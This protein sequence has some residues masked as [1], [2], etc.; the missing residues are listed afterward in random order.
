MANSSS[1]VDIE[2]ALERLMPRGLGDET[3]ARLEVLIDELASE[4]EGKQS[5]S[6]FWDHP[7]LGLSA[8][9]AV[10]LAGAVYAMWERPREVLMAKQTAAALGQDYGQ[11]E[12]LTHRVWIEGGENLGILSVGDAGDARQG[13]SYSGVEEERFLHGE[14]GYEVIIQREFEGEHYA[15]TTL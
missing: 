15:T 6:R 7:W 13:W 12:L 1:R 10:I 9:A 8:A 3:Q 2:S 14:S 4:S 11:I 5:T